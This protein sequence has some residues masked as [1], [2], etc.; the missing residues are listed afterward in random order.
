MYVRVMCYKIHNETVV[1][2]YVKC[3]FFF[4][5]KC[6]LRELDKAMFFFCTSGHFLI[7]FALFTLFQKANNYPTVFSIIR[8]SLF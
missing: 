7:R 3:G 6:H 2:G 1:F 5:S 4:F 8:V